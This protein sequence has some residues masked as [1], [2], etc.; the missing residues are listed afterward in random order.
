MQAGPVKKSD[1]IPF[2]EDVAEE[3]TAL[4]KTGMDRPLIPRRSILN[5]VKPTETKMIPVNE[6]NAEE[7][8]VPIKKTGINNPRNNP[9]RSTLERSMALKRYIDGFQRMKTFIQ[10]SWSGKDI[11]DYFLKGLD[12]DIRQQ[13]EIHEPKTCGE[14][15]RIAIGI[16][17]VISQEQHQTLEPRPDPIRPRTQIRLMKLTPQERL[18]LRRTGS[19]FRCR[20]K[21][22]IA[23]NCPSNTRY[24]VQREERGMNGRTSGVA[25]SQGIYIREDDDTPGIREERYKLDN[26][27]PILLRGDLNGQ[28]VTI[29][30]NTGAR[31]NYVSRVLARDVYTRNIKRKDKGREFDRS[32]RGVDLVHSYILRIETYEECLSFEQAE[33]PHDI[34]LGMDW[35]I[36]HNTNMDFEN[37]RSIS[38]M[39]RCIIV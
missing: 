25:A 37:K 7:I 14:A 16:N 21:G 22:N 20:K 3:I 11:L 1:S 27:S 4:V 12:D 30:I 34:I 32:L 15:E 38:T 8:T 31:R 28:P 29:L 35:L 2:D 5:E 10:H 26:P 23:M 9:R 13:V 17:N 39:R 6:N 18:Q 36:M 19:C 24:L 33:I